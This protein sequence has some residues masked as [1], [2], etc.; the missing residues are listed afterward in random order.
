MLQ[1]VLLVVSLCIDAF[2]A[3]FA[4]GSNKIKIPFLSGTV[5]TFISTLFLVISLAL[6][7]FI[8]SFLP[9]TIAP[10][11]CFTLL[12]ILGIVRLFEGLI[13]NFLNQ[14]ALSPNH[15]ELT[16]FDF[17]LILN[18]YADAT[19]ADIDHSKVLSTKEALYLGIALSLDSLAVG[20]SVSLA[21]INF[22]E[23]I[24]FSLVFNALALLLGCALGQR[25]AEKVE[26]DLSWVSGMILILLAFLKLN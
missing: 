25:L 21:V 8:K 4:Y 6:G 19:R 15:I 18:V 11:I 12:F 9:N 10:F 24:I 22:Y 13:K 14:K 17:K 7:T 1:S 20:L 2:A 23:I 16:I 26:T 5:M 3:S